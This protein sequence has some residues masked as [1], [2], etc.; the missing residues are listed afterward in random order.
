MLLKR[1][2]TRKP[3]PNTRTNPPGR[4]K[5]NRRVHVG[6]PDRAN[7]GTY[8]AIVEAGV[9]RFHTTANSIVIFLIEGRKS[10]LG[11]SSRLSI[12]E[13]VGFLNVVQ[14]RI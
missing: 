2:I 5:K 3:P 10:K 4:A 9:R 11:L 7:M 8:D 1:D 12:G 6:L 13:G 14:S